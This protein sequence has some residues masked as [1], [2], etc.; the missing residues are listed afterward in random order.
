MP[1][2]KA[3]AIMRRM[4]HR[5]RGR[6]VMFSLVIAL[7]ASTLG[8]ARESNQ[9]SQQ[10]TFRAGIDMVTL[11]VVPRNENGRFVPDLVAED[12][13]VLEDAVPQK[14]ASLVLV[15]GGRVF[16]LAAPAAPAAAPDGLVLP[17]ARAA[18]DAGGRVF[19]LIV[20]DLHFTATETPIV[21]ALLRK[22][23][24]RLFHD[25]DMVA[26]F[27]TGPSSIE[28]PATYDRKLLEGVVSKVAGHGM[29]YRDIMDARDG[30]QGPQGL[31]YNAHVAFKTAYELLGNLDRVRN[32]RKAVILVSKGYDFDPFPAGRTGTDQVFGGRYGSPWVNPE[33]GDRFL[34]LGQT[35]NRFADA[36][37]ASELAAITGIANRVNASIYA[38][39]P[40]GVAGTTSVAEQVDM[41]E[42]RT[43]LGK[44]QASLQVLSEATGGFAVINDNTYDEALKRIDAETSD[45]YILGYYA[46][47]TDAARR[48]RQ[49]EVKTTR[50]GVQVA[51][52][53][54][55]RTRAPSR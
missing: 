29:S 47:N 49:V 32:R 9:S 43:H 24:A 50:P 37:L 4:A 25:G 1:R 6:G 7:L 12:F 13:H 22:T 31:R 46:T 34:A 14:V 55:Y 8:D 28:V 53:G 16:N 11:D 51:S 40:R 45:Y 36:D 23:I 38:I 17:Q 30:A 48:N 26:M 42:M 54:W 52:R 2:L 35:T 21:R 41:T 18:A 19:V 10:P 39:D 44:T 5:V 20:D 27:S 3:V 33:S 15:N